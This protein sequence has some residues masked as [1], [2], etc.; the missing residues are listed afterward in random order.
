MISV[1][2]R[3]GPRGGEHL[4]GRVLSSANFADSVIAVLEQ[5]DVPAERLILE[6]TETALLTDPPRAVAIIKALDDQAVQ[7]S[8]DD[9]RRGQT[10]LGHLSS[11]PLHELKIDRSFVWDMIEN[12][13]HMAIVP[14]IVDLGPNLSFRVVAEG[15]ETSRVLD[16]F[17]SLGCDEAQG[18]LLCHRGGSDSYNP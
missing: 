18:F 10:S 17:R 8:T 6:V 5:L 1:I 2:F 16:A 14:S 7:V 9:F 11:L 4:S 13:S 3:G 12:P 15:V